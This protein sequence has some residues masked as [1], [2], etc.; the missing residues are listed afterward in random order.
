MGTW[1]VH[2]FFFFKFSCLFASLQKEEE[3]LR[4]SAHQETLHLREKQNQQG[5]S[6]HI[7]DP[8]SDKEGNETVK[9]HHQREHRGELG[10]EV[11]LCHLRAVGTLVLLRG[12]GEGAPVLLLFIQDNSTKAFCFCFYFFLT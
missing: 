9:N 7:Q 11:T 2:F 3:R 12:A 8:S 10:G 5:P 4:A 6:A 1:L